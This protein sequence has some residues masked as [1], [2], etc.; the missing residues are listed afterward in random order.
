MIGRQ[1]YEF[2]G[3]YWL[4]PVDL[5]VLQGLVAMAPIDDERGRMEVRPD[6]QS[7]LGK[8]LREGLAASGQAEQKSTVALRTSFYELGKEIGYGPN[9][10]GGGSLTVVLKRSV[11][12]LWMTSLIVE[13]PETK[14]RE[15]SRLISRYQS[16]KNGFVVALNFSIASIVL[17]VSKRY[18]RISMAEIRAL[19]TDP[20][21]LMHQRLC[22]WIDPGKTGRIELDTLCGYA[23]FEQATNINT[24]KWR[25]KTARKALGEFAALGW[26]IE[27]Y[28]KNKFA[29]TRRGTAN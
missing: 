13:D 16:D 21:R 11:E 15:G 22:A 23:W 26:E 5:R 14:I 8:F 29:I 3:P 25:R 20:A 18:T 17:G 2:R 6:T 1:R 28:V 4:G 12:H 7:A 27:E 9:S 19:K 10:C 24:L